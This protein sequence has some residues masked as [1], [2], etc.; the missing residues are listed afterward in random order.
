[1]IRDV[2][3]MGDPRLLERSREVAG[4]RI[5]GDRSAARRH[6]R[7]D[8]RAERRRPRRAADRRA[9]ARRD[10][11]R[12]AQSALSRCRAGAVHRAHQSGAD[13]A[14][15][16]DGGG[17]GRVPVGARAARRRAAPRAAALRGTSTRPASRSSATSTGSTRA[18]CSTSATTS[19]ASS[20]RCA[21]RDFTRF[22]FTD[23]LF[24]GAC[25]LAARLKRRARI[26]RNTVSDPHFPAPDFHA[27]ASCTLSCS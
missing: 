26:S 27:A 3:R 13:A 16:R 23:V 7:H 10:L 14:V 19:T 2:L 20:I 22:G 4:C 9:A 11:R 17:L 5:A 6:A 18:S 21:M 8:A 25:R 1:M 15:R 12:R 24:P